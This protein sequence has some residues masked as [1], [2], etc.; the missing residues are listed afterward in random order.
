MS[1]KTVWQRISTRIGC[2]YVGADT[3][4]EFILYCVNYIVV[5]FILRRNPHL[6]LRAKS[7]RLGRKY[8]R[9][10]IYVFKEARLPS[11]DTEKE[12]F[13]VS[14]SFDDTF[15]VYLN[16]DD[17]YDEAKINALYKF[18][19]EGPYGLRNERVDV[20]VGD[21][22][23]GGVSYWTREAGLETLRLTRRLRG[24]WSTPSSRPMKRKNT[25]SRRR[26]STKTFIP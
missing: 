5:V 11:L 25:L 1:L 12:Y 18:L 20:T 16:C 23:G 26:S 19:P 2:V 13:F 24:R 22:M 21:N 9:D 10:G 17:C 7:K 4:W 15:F 3:L 6:H 14:S 8:L